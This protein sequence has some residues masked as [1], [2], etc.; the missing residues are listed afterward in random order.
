MTPCILISIGS[1]IDPEIHIP[2]GLEQ[3]AKLVRIVKVSTFYRSPALNR[4]GDPDF[5]NG[6]CLV[7]T[8]CGPRMLKYEVLRPIERIQGRQRGGD[9][10]APRPLDLDIALWGDTC[11]DEEG[12]M[13]PD[14]DICRRACLCLPLAELAPGAPVPGAAITL[15]EAAAQLDASALTPLP[16]FTRTLHS[17]FLP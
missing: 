11:I 12:L 6:A 3:L 8:C 14:P 10:Y 15:G 9:P 16:E 5:Y 1:N 4:P 17:R 7:D 2:E 13:L